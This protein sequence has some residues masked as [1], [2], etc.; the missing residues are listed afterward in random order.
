MFAF[1]AGMG[2]DVVDIFA[3]AVAYKNLVRGVA[4]VDSGNHIKYF[5]NKL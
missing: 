4:I 1:T 5:I 2:L 3:K